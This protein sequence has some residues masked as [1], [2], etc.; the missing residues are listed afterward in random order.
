MLLFLQVSSS[1]FL[2]FS[3]SPR[4][5][6]CVCPAL[7]VFS[8]TCIQLQVS[9][10]AFARFSQIFD[11]VENLS[12]SSVSRDPLIALIP[13]SIAFFAFPCLLLAPNCPLLSFPVLPLI[14]FSCPLLPSIIYTST[15][16]HQSLCPSTFYLHT[17]G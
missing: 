2:R 3:L 5:Q 14:A 13:P 10:P 9:S 8:S 7:H 12:I 11:L 1:P 15:Y 4:L 6:L 16:Q 17:Q